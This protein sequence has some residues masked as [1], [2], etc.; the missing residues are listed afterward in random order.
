MVSSLGISIL[1]SPLL[2]VPE[3]ELVTTQVILF[4]C[5][6]KLRIKTLLSAVV[7]TDKLVL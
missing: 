6:P 2:S 3:E 7:L 5:P 4:V 1:H